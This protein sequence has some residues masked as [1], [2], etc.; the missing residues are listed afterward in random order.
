[1][2]LKQKFFSLLHLAFSASAFHYEVIFQENEDRLR[3]YGKNVC[4]LYFGFLNFGKRRYVI[5]SDFVRKAEVLKTRMVVLEPFFLLNWY[6][7][8]VFKL[9]FRVIKGD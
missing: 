7:K 8:I 3:G 6:P 1:M 5:C 2:F 4:I 9:S